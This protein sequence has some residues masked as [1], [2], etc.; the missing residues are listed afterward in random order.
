MPTI[1][2]VVISEQEAELA[3]KVGRADSDVLLMAMHEYPKA[4]QAELALKCGWGADG[5]RDN[6]RDRPGRSK[7]R[8]CLATLK[9]R[10]LATDHSGDWTLTKNGKAFAKELVEERESKKQF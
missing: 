6:G 2:M 4:S 1:R 9:T 10:R 7:V 3:E 8:R 5:I